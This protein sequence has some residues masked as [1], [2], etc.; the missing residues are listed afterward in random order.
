MRNP[1]S[2]AI[3]GTNRVLAQYRTAAIAVLGVGAPIFFTYWVQTHRYRWLGLFI[4]AMFV[5]II[6]SVT[7]ARY[8]KVQLLATVIRAIHTALQ[9]GDDERITL[10]L[11]TNARREKYQQIVDYYPTAY[12]G[13][14]RVFSF[15]H[16]IVGQ[17]LKQREW[18][19]WTVPEGQNFEQ[20]MRESW[21]FSKD[22]LKR[23]TQDRLS[24][25]AYPIGELSQYAKAVIYIDSP[26]RRFNPAT[27][28]Q[29]EETMRTLFSPLLEDIFRD[30]D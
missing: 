3:Y 6:A 26:R 4:G 2:S 16:G 19:W 29:T 25:F 27:A 20:A 28:A 8:A 5:V 10:H 18:H 14:G 17:V 24:F 1:V 21:G 30:I 11:I 13:R 22:E 9:L 7:P 15:S 12:A 23:L